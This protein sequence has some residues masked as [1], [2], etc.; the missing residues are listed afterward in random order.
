MLKCIFFIL[1]VLFMYCILADAKEFWEDIRPMSKKEKALAEHRRKL[2]MEKDKEATDKGAYFENKIRDMILYYFPGSKVQQNI[3][4]RNGKFSK[5]IDLIALTP[6]GFF[7]V[8][9][10]N[11]NG[12]TISGKVNEKNWTCFYNEDNQYSLYN[13]IFQANSG[14]W[15]IKKHIENIHLDRAVVFSNNCK[16]SKDILN[17]AGVYTLSSFEEALEE[18]QEKEDIYND[19]AIEQIDEIISSLDQVSRSEHIKN[20]EKIKNF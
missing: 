17:K 13:P 11:Y 16:L 18:L 19:A 15:N 20:V 4:V 7:L 5:E 2:M 12:C 3:I 10:K 14:I 8:E 9:A 1:F 6:K